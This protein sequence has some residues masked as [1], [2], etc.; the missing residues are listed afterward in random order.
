MTD[1]E[2]KAAPKETA[3]QKAAVAA[4]EKA[5]RQ[6]DLGAS[7]VRDLRLAAD[8]VD[9][10]SAGRMSKKDFQSDVLKMISKASSNASSFGSGMPDD[11]KA[12]PLDVYARTTA[13]KSAA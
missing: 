13:D 10:A 12:D 4:S 11:P 2:T 3:E 5:A 7:V 9:Q 8:L 1:S 6:R